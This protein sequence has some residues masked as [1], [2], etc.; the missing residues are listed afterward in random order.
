MKESKYIR[1]LLTAF[2]ILALVIPAIASSS[3]FVNAE[4]KTVVRVSYS[5]LNLSNDAGVATL[6]RRIQNATSAVC[7]AQRSFREAGSQEQLRHNKQC[8]RNTVSKL[9]AKV[10]N[11]DLTEMH[12]GY[13]TLVAPEAGRPAV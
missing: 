5:D 8:Y 11:A 13:P 7:G 2:A 3:Q 1:K 12:I 4:G 6:Y 10:G 9:V